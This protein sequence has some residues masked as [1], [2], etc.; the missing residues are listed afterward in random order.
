M[1]PKTAMKSNIASGYPPT[2][3]GKFDPV[4]LDKTDPKLL[5]SKQDSEEDQ[6]KELEKE[7]NKLVEESAIFKLEGRSW[8]K[9]L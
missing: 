9:S 1:P 3:G 6:F 8:D 7:V 2:R 4:K 5:A